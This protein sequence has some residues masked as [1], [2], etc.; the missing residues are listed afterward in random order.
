MKSSHVRRASMLAVPIVTALTWAATVS[1]QGAP[2]PAPP[3]PPAPPPPAAAPAPPPPPPAAPAAKWYEKAKIEGFVDAYFNLNW[4][5]PKPQTGT[6]LGRAFDV[7][8]GFAV[9]W[10]GLNASYAPDPVGG[11]VSLRFGP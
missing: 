11:T 4:N 9:N 1:A 6:D 8:N 7:T 2:P 3:A 5:F 10:V